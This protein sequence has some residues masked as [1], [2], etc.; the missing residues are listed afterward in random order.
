M[1]GA[2]QKKRFRAPLPGAALFLSMGEITK[3]RKNASIGP[4]GRQSRRLQLVIACFFKIWKLF[5]GLNTKYGFSR[6]G[7]ASLPRAALR[8]LHNCVYISFCDKLQKLSNICFSLAELGKLNYIYKHG[9][10]TFCPPVHIKPSS[11][12]PLWWSW[13]ENSWGLP[14]VF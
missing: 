1:S 2:P 5:R 8:S 13:M 3:K 12:P 14:P 7:L 9:F 4:I 10:F 11:Y 6:G